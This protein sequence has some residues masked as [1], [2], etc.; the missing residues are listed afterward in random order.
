MARIRRVVVPR[1]ERNYLFR[2]QARCAPVDAVPE[3]PRADTGV[4]V[5]RFPCSDQELLVAARAA[6][7][8][9]GIGYERRRTHGDLLG[10]ILHGDV[11]AHRALL[12]VHGVAAMEGDPRAVRLAP[13]QGYIHWC[14][15]APA[16]RGHGL[17]PYMLATLARESAR[18]LGLEEIFIA[19]RQNN[20]AS[21]RGIVKAGFIYHGSSLAVSVLSG[22][23]SHSRWSVDAS[24]PAAARNA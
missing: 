6:I 8:L 12:Q 1:V 23:I 4:Y 7:G 24:P 20:A 3:L 15:T 9:T 22:R 11:I 19:C 18:T 17:Y 2:W 10:V 16:H 21:I 5:A 13:K 14:E